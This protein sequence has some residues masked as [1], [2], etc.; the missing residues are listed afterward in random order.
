MIIDD[1]S[2]TSEESDREY[3]NSVIEGYAQSISGELHEMGFDVSIEGFNKH[4]SFT[5]ESFRSTLLLA[6][7]LDHPFQ[8]IIEATVETLVEEEEPS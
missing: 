5:M 4:F 7:G 1:S 8:E 6:L 3:V 2:E